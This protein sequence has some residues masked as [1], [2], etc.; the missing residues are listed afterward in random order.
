[1]NI[2]KLIKSFIKNS[3]SPQSEKE[4]F[5]LNLLYSETYLSECPSIPSVNIFLIPSTLIGLINVNIYK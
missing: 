4:K 5:F 1:M 2:S 3:M